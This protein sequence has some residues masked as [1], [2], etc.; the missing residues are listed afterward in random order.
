MPVRDSAFLTDAQNFWCA[1]DVNRYALQFWPFAV[2]GG[3]ATANGST[4]ELSTLIGFVDGGY[5]VEDDDVPLA[6]NPSTNC[7]VVA[8]KYTFGDLAPFTRVAGTHWL[9]NC[10]ATK[11]SPFPLSLMWIAKAETDGSSNITAI[12]DLRGFVPGTRTVETEAELNDLLS[13]HKGQQAITTDTGI[14]YYFFESEDGVTAEWQAVGIEGNAVQTSGDQTIAGIKTFS[15]F[16]RMDTGDA[17]PA[18]A[19]QFA[20]KFYVDQ[21]AGSFTGS[22]I[23]DPASV[24]S[25]GLLTAQVTVTGVTVEDYACIAVFGGINVLTPF[26]VTAHVIAANTVG[27]YMTNLGPLA[28]NLPSARLR[29]RCMDAR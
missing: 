12:T 17:V 7:W 27:V 2:M 13:I 26:H 25:S 29:V 9:K 5:V 21:E 6:G 19:N 8:S 22:I 20:T 16:P 3:E 14:L 1:E 23:F 28:V 24:D 4:L 15:S 10:G 11:P 18:A